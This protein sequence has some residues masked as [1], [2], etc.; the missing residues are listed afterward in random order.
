MP[1]S[2]KGFTL[3]ELLVVISLIAILSTIG[4]A[5][6]SGVQK[7]A[8]ISKRVQDLK[9]IQA[10][11]EIYFQTN[12]TYP[13]TS[14]SWRS[15][16]LSWSSGVTGPDDVVKDA[17]SGNT[18]VPSYMLSFPSDPSMSKQNSTSCYRYRS[19]GSDYKLQDY[20]VT[21]MN[22]A[23]FQS[24]NS[25]I[26]PASDGGDC[27]KVDGG[28]PTAWAVYSS[29]TGLNNNTNPACWN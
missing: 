2:A 10:A 22:T 8:R 4:V 5:V 21:E 26:D 29:N 23:D 7:Q 25:L 14:G 28:A 16:C 20:N 13:T 11:L 6:Y 3:V 17:V 9:S 19:N 18:L 12:K 27:S 1:K 15:E 24:Q